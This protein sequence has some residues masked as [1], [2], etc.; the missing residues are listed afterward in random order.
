MAS[1]FSAE[2]RV[3]P[4]TGTP[5]QPPPPPPHTH[6]ANLGK[7]LPLICTVRSNLLMSGCDNSLGG[8]G[9]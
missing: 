3:R 7:H 5:V 4:T 6:L 8:D 9:T 1:W 2:C